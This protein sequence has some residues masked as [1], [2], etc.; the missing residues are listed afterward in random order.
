MF[1]HLLVPIDLSDRN[2]RLLAV[3]LSLAREGGGR[4]TL[5]HVVQRIQDTSPR[6]LRSFYRKLEQKSRRKL[7][8]A[9]RRFVARDVPVRTAVVIGEP[10]REI[11]RA[12]ASAADRVD[13]VVMGSHKVRPG[14]RGWGTTSYKVGIACQCPILLV[15]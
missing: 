14:S 13:L 4:V 1:R 15:K 3:A 2:A 11:I 7:D 9:A 5:L 6:E 12:S 8:A 10:A